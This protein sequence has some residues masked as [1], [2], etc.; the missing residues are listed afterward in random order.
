MAVGK[1]STDQYSFSVD[2][3]GTLK[4]I[5]FLKLNKKLSK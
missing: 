3:Q 5:D 1:I 2:P 4:P